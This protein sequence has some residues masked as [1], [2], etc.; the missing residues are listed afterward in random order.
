MDSLVAI[1]KENQ[2]SFKTD[3]RWRIIFLSFSTVTVEKYCPCKVSRNDYILEK[4][5]YIDTI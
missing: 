1:P 2:N 3:S 5:I 4:I